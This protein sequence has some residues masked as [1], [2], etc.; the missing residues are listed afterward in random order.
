MN[1]AYEVADANGRNPFNSTV[2]VERLKKFFVECPY[3]MNEQSLE[4]E[5]DIYDEWPYDLSSQETDKI[6]HIPIPIQ[7]PIQNMQEA[8]KEEKNPEEKKEKPKILER[9]ERNKRSAE[10]KDDK[11]I[12]PRDIKTRK[13]LVDIMQEKGLQVKGTYTDLLAT[14]ECRYNIWHAA[15]RNKRN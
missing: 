10:I 14:Y 8:N 13:Q 12:R 15:T 3:E 7:I 6:A 11:W 5:I 9:G 2:N 4:E 1:N